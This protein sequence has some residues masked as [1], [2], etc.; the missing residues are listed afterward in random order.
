V[1]ALLCV[2]ADVSY[3]ANSSNGYCLSVFSGISPV[4]SLLP[5]NQNDEETQIHIGNGG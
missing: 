3:I 2:Q 1:E 4:S 5:T